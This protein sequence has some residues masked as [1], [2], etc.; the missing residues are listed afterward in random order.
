MALT[1]SLNALAGVLIVQSI[2]FLSQIQ[3]LLCMNSNVGCLSLCDSNLAYVAWLTT[4]NYAASRQPIAAH[5]HFT[6]V[7]IPN[8][9]NRQ[10]AI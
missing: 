5:V 2:Q 4:C 8:A 6:P 10:A 7:N 1:K 3:Y 9:N